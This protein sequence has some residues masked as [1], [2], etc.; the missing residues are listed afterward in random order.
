MRRF[1]SLSWDVFMVKKIKGSNSKHS[2]QTLCQKY[3]FYIFL[4]R[5]SHDSFQQ[6]FCDPLGHLTLYHPLYSYHH[7]SKKK[8][9]DFCQ[10]VYSAKFKML[11]RVFRKDGILKLKI[12]ELEQQYSYTAVIILFPR[13]QYGTLRCQINRGKGRGRGGQVNEEGL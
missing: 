11:E 7:L 4:K 1:S 6:I 10:V 12:L 13:L 9:R 5:P 8:S 3:S 2:S